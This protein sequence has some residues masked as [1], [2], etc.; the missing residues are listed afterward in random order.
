MEG[1]STDDNMIFLEIQVGMLYNKIIWFL[2][3]KITIVRF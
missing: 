2:G 3:P 1:V